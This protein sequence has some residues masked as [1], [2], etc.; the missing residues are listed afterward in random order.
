MENKSKIGSFRKHTLGLGYDVAVR[1]QTVRHIDEPVCIASVDRNSLKQQCLNKNVH[2]N[3]LHVHCVK[4]V[5]KKWTQTFDILT[6]DNNVFE[7]KCYNVTKHC[8]T[9]LANSK[10]K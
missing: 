1:T 3:R 4:R 2:Q 9:S 7:K 6:D 5:K 8:V 10:V